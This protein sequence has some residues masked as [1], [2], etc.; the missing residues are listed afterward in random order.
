[1][2]NRREFLKGAASFGGAPMLSSLGLA[3][4]LL[5]QGAESEPSRITLPPLPYMSELLEPHLDG[6]TLRIHHMKHH[7]LHVIELNR[8]LGRLREAREKSDYADVQE[9]SRALAVH[10]GGHLNHTIYFSSMAPLGR[11]GGEEPKGALAERITR[12]FGSYEQFKAHFTAAALSVQGNGWAVL[13][14]HP[15][16]D[17]L[18]ISVVSEDQNLVPL[19]LV[20]LLMIDMWEHAY[21]L[22][23]QN[24]R[25]EYVKAWWNIVYWKDAAKRYATATA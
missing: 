16:L 23:Y 10:A 25:R 24:K 1:M 22:K 4:M 3:D 11:G 21:Y 7:A 19:G 8:V 14:Y 17:R 12:D 6:R 5:A 13:A 2:T 18:L 9:L 15:L 20:P